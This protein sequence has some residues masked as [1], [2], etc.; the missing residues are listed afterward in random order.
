MNKEN[1]TNFRS[2]FAGIIGAPNAG[3]S[4]LLNQVLGQKISITSKKPQ[5]TRDRILGIVNTVSSQIVFVDT[6]G[7]HK[8]TTLLNRRIVDQALLALEDVDVILFMVDAAARNYSA[9]KL[10]ISQLKKTSKPV[11]LALNKIDLVDKG[12]VYRLVEEFRKLHDF[13]AIIPVSAIKDIQVKNLIEEVESLLAKGPRLFPEET[14]TDVSEKFMVKEIIREKVFRLTGME[15]PYSSAV[16]VD[17]FKM[18]K[19]LIVIHASIHVVRD[20][21]KGIIIGKKGSMLS[22]IGSKARKDIEKMTGQKVLL[23]L[24][25]KVTKNWI[26]NGRMLS[27]FGY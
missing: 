9:E 27:E 10:I 12:L 26:D 3:K 4:T 22:K 5:T 13:K 1:E 2:G 20:S 8:S 16:T 25:V 11:V 21:Q 19:K 14:F 23:K 6:P 15:I 24:F 7:I 17:S 18:E